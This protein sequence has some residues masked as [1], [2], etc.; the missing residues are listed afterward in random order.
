MN[1]GALQ[2]ITEAIPALRQKM[3]R[4]YG[5]HPYFTRRPPNVVLAYIGR[6]STFGD[7][8]LDPFGGTG[9][10]AI[11]ALLSGRRAIHND[12]NPFANFITANIAD[13]SLPTTAPLKHAINRIERS[14]AGRLHELEAGSESVA[15]ALIPDLPLPENIRLPRSSDVEFFYDLFTR[16][17]IVALALLKQAIDKE[18]AE[19]V[20]G[21]LLLAWS[22]AA[23]KLN[24]TFLSAEGRAE[25]RGGSSIFSIYR[26]KV[27]D[28]CVELPLWETFK[29]RF[30]NILNAKEEVLRFRDV[31]NQTHDS[32]H[33]VDSGRNLKI[34]GHDAARLTEVIGRE[35]VDYIFT[36]P[37][38]GGHIAYL[39]LSVLWNHWLGQGVSPEVRASEAI[40]GGELKLSEDHYKERLAES[41][42]QCFSM[43]KA[44]RWFSIV[45]QHWDMS[46]FST[47]LQA[48]EEGGGELRSAVTQEGDVIWSMHKKK[49]SENVLSGEM[50]LS[51][52]KPRR[53]RVSESRKASSVKLTL[54]LSDILDAVLPRNVAKQATLTTESL[55][56]QVIVEA[57]RR[58]C[59][60]LMR[61][62]REE[63][64]RE[65][66]NRGW[67]YTAEK[68]CWS[69][70]EKAEESA[71]LFRVDKHGNNGLV[72]KDRLRK[73]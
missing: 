36:D 46:Y 38:Y 48:S 62:T 14:C 70:G 30:V 1:R 2:P 59:L 23:A 61:T 9:V 54:T 51:F 13:T 24:K 29:G 16:K 21:P 41:V 35:S 19:N 12:L 67:E 42:K 18:S 58:R 71:S 37:P 53:A 26:Y 47:I 72:R 56:N 49:N 68:H 65:L 8:V 5:A 25:S 69:R 22:A 44:D 31:F 57:W 33:H 3:A 10:T 4:H 6:H 45:F 39:D 7:V 52:Y 20:R 43:L 17:Q 63:F 64:S 15:K 73:T 50:I 28:R 27:A 40:V 60:A 66:R 34:Y 55:L 32:K 11:E